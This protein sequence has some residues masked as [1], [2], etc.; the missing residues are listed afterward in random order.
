MLNFN[1]NPSNSVQ[2]LIAIAKSTKD[3]AVF[4]GCVRK[5]ETLVTEIEFIAI[6]SKL[7]V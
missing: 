7:E 5:I 1:L 6:C 4:Y 3:V 2:E